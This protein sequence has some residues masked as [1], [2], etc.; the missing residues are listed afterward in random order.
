MTRLPMPLRMKDERDR[1]KALPVI[2][3]AIRDGA[4][5]AQ[6]VAE[7]S[8]DLPDHF[9]SRPG[10]IADRLSKF[11]PPA[12]TPVDVHAASIAERGIFAAGQRPEAA[13]S[14]TAQELARQAREA[15][16]QPRGAVPDK[17]NGT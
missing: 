14:R 8:R 9:K 7:L 15:L 2:A 4:T 13:D 5:V 12:S 17:R 11:V 16:K 10:F 1:H 6:L 3:A